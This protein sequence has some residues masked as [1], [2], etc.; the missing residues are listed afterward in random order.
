MDLLLVVILGR[1]GDDPLH[2]GPGFGSLKAGMNDGLEDLDP[3]GQKDILGQ[4]VVA[5]DPLGEREK[6]AGAASDPGFAVAFQ[7]KAVFGGLLELRGGQHVEI[8]RHRVCAR[9]EYSSQ[10]QDRPHSRELRPLREPIGLPPRST[11]PEEESPG[12]NH[13][14]TVRQ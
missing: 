9:L 11:V 6:A 8:A 5:R 4:A 14:K 3:T 13:R 12:S 1:I 10:P 2:P 7:Q